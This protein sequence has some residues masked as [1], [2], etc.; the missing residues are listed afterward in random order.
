ML[1]L[2]LLEEWPGLVETA[3][4]P[5][6]LGY[7]RSQR[8]KHPLRTH[9]HPVVFGYID[10]S[11]IPVEFHRDT[12]EETFRN[13][14]RAWIKHYTGMND[15]P[16]SE[17]NA[18]QM[19]DQLLNV[20]KNTSLQDP[21]W[22]NPIAAFRCA[23]YLTQSQTG[24]LAFVGIAH[25]YRGMRTGSNQSFY[26]HI[27]ERTTET[28]HRLASDL[29]HELQG[30]FAEVH[31]AAIDESRLR[32]QGRGHPQTSDATVKAW[33]RIGKF[34]HYG[35]RPVPIKYYDM[36]DGDGE[37]V[38]Y[39]F[40]FQPD[41]PRP[42]MDKETIMEAV[43]ELHA[44]YRTHPTHLDDKKNGL[45]AMRQQANISEEAWQQAAEKFD[46]YITRSANAG[47]ATGAL[48]P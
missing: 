48:A 43:A 35:A 25:A 27:M 19:I 15:I 45:D 14:G 5:T 13:Y 40:P 41:A 30:I 11:I 10:P 9:T 1:E 21:D 3:E 16:K 34:K 38:L 37:Y 42:C 46:D 7:V 4:H 36:Y 6:S 28:F 29:G 33:N 2:R 12:A 18:C 44:A 31:N 17:E 20:T 8:G 24:F 22:P 23:S 32:A 39:S 47:R 26:R